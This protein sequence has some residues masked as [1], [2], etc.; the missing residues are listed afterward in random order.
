MR[1]TLPARARARRDVHARVAEQRLVLDHALEARLAVGGLGQRLAVDDLGAAD[2]RVDAIFA[3][4]PV[5]DDVEVEL[6][7]A[8]DDRLPGLRVLVDVEGG[9]LVGQL[10][11]PE[12]QLLALGLRL[13]LDRARITGS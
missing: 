1:S 3:A 13:R 9:I 12:V 2:V 10:L 5:D 8:A 7:H 4:Q 6:A 11:E